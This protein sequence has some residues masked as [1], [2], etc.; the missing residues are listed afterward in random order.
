[1]RTLLRGPVESPHGTAQAAQIPGVH[2]AGKT[3]TT[4]KLLKN[5]TFCNRFN[6]PEGFETCP[7]EASFVGMVPA[8]HPRFVLLVMVDDPQPDAT[9]PLIEGGLVAAPAF[10]EIATKMLPTFGIVPSAR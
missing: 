10:H 5:G 2:V 3:G 9:H 6:L 8:E 1:M 7:V 4:P